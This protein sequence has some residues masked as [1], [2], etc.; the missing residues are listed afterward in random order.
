MRKVVK[1]LSLLAIICCILCVFVACGSNAGDEIPPE[2]EEVAEPESEPHTEHAFGDWEIVTQPTC[3]EP[4]LQ[5][6]TCACGETETE[7]LYPLGHSTVRH[8]RKEATC[9]EDGWETYY[10]CTRCDYTTYREIKA[11]GHDYE[12]GVCRVCGY[13]DLTYGTEGLQ[14]TLTK[15]DTYSVT[16]YNGKPGAIVIPAI[17]NGKPVTSIGDSCFYDAPIGRIK[18]PDSVTSI[19]DKAFSGSYLTDITIPDSVTYIGDYA[20]PNNNLLCNEYEGGRYIGNETNPYVVFIGVANPY[21]SSYYENITSCTIH[22]N[23]K[24]INGRA[25]YECLSLAN[26]TIPDSVTCIGEHA[27]YK[28]SS[29]TSITLPN[30][31]THIGEDAFECCS[32]LRNISIPDSVTSVGL[33]A[34]AECN[35]LQ[36]NQ[37]EN[38]LYLGNETNPYVVLKAATTKTIRS[39]TIHENTKVIYPF[40]FQQRTNLTSITIPNSVTYIGKCAFDACTSL[41]NVNFGNGLTKI[42]VYA[43]SGCVGIT[44]ITIPDSV[45]IIEEGVF[46]GMGLTSITIPA[47]IERIDVRAFSDCDNLTSITVDSNNPVYHSVGNCIIQT[48]EKMLVIGCKNSVIPTDG[49]VTSIGRYAFYDCSFTSFTIPDIIT[50]IPEGAFAVCASLTSI[51]IPDSVTSIDYIAF[52]QC[53]SLTTITFMGTMEQWNA[54]EKESNWDFL[55]GSYTVKCTDGDITVD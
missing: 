45:A 48:K 55:A 2:I 52:Y 16:G 9:T 10:T 31:V 41:A 53:S 47:S 19:G 36:Y 38:A 13:K 23:T 14:F 42:G 46:S 24:V 54:I 51:T 28:C 4:G 39:C 7:T 18:I 29:L 1:L 35:Q 27:F 37:Y 34:F 6:R 25:F 15:D 43:F 12:D 33:T 26:I 17:Y 50:V 11:P 30:G 44:N 5:Q 32:G 49:S 20:I 8:D 3:T 40:A 21:N 22:E